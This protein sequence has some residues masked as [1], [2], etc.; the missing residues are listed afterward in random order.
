[1]NVESDDTG[2]TLYL[3]YGGHVLRSGPTPLNVTVDLDAEATTKVGAASKED[4]YH[5]DR[6]GIIWVVSDKG[7]SITLSGDPLQ[8]QDINP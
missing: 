6:A 8:N 2:A 4:L 3:V 5:S 7:G 1:V